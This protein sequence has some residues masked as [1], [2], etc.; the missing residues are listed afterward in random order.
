[1][2]T[3]FQ[4]GRPAYLRLYTLLREEILRGERQPGEK[5]PSRR[6]LAR[7][8]GLS[9]ITVE[10][11]LDLLIQEG[12]VEARPKS[13]YY[14]IYRETDGFAGA[15]EPEREKAAD[16]PGDPPAGT[17]TEP[18]ETDEN[19]WTAAAAEHR[20]GETFPFST[21]AKTMRRVLA[22]RGEDI[23]KKTDNPGAPELREAISR[24]LGRNREIHTDPR[25]IIVGSGAEYLYGLVVEMLGRERLFAIESPSYAKIRQVYEAKGVR[26]DQLPLGRHGI[27]TEALQRTEASVLHITPFRSFPSGVTA[28]AW[29]RS[30]A[31]SCTCSRRSRRTARSISST[32]PAPSSKPS[33]WRISPRSRRTSR[34]STS[35]WPSTVRIRPPTPP[36]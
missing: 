30:A 9:V 18:G 3:R 32:V 16:R 25:Q 20:D 35:T 7:D 27:R 23:L 11:S 2:K 15:A 4:D 14:V 6:E 10:H 13:G 26:C 24:Y 29:L 17:E 19:P 22:E 33:T 31:T 34:T 28:T 12:Y 5:L 1:M 8:H 36:A 21:L